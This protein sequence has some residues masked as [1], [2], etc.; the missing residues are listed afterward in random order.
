MEP[1]DEV[2][3]LGPVALQPD[4]G[5]PVDAV[6][7][8]SQSISPHIWTP[9]DISKP[10]RLRS[11]TS[12]FSKFN[13]FT[14]IEDKVYGTYL[15]KELKKHIRKADE[16]CNSVHKEII[17]TEKEIVAL[18]NK[19]DPADERKL[20]ELLGN[21][22]TLK[23]KLPELENI[24]QA[25]Q[26]LEDFQK[27]VRYSRLNKEMRTRHKYPLKSLVNH[28]QSLKK[29]AISSVDL[30]KALSQT[31]KIKAVSIDSNHLENVAR[32]DA[33]NRMMTT[34]WATVSKLQENST[35]KQTSQFGE[36]TKDGGREVTENLERVNTID[37]LAARYQVETAALETEIATAPEE[38]KKALQERLGALEKLENR[39]KG[40]LE[41]WRMTKWIDSSDWRQLAKTADTDLLEGIKI[42]PALRAD[43]INRLLIRCQGE[44]AKIEALPEHDK[45]IQETRRDALNELESQCVICWDR[46]QGPRSIDRDEWMQLLKLAA[47]A[48]LLHETVPDVRYGKYVAPVIVN[49][50]MHSVQAGG[51]SDEFH[52]SGAITDFRDGSTNL[53]DL[54]QADPHSAETAD[55][56]AVLD[57]QMVQLLDSQVRGWLKRQENLKALPNHFVLSQTSLLN[58]FKAKEVKEG[59]F[60]RSERNYM[61]D[62]EE[63]FK[64]FNN[65][66]LVLDPKATVAY[67]DAD[68][69]IHIPAEGLKA[70]KEITLTTSFFN[71]SVQVTTKNKGIQ[72][73]VNDLAFDSLRARVK[74]STFEGLP[75]QYVKTVTLE[76]LR[77]D[78]ITKIND[79]Q[80]RL[81]EEGGSYE[82]AAQLIHLQEEVALSDGAGSAKGINCF[83][84]KDRTGEVAKYLVR[85][86][87]AKALNPLGGMGK[88]EKQK[89]IADFE[90]HLA[91]PE[92]L[93]L[94]N[95]YENTGVRVMRNA[96]ITLLG[97]DSL[98][99]RVKRGWTAYGVQE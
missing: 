51:Y 9:I 25:A 11:G 90:K 75:K 1:I 10:P 36:V 5:Q 27:V 34:I 65:K 13:F 63:I 62:M 49:A 80:T 43:F 26:H 30:V 17:Q 66:T 73:E 77:E 29:R 91:S 97:E 56:R 61:L 82:L 54:E 40:C 52:Q 14:W 41:N 22:E 88:E 16:Y 53:R 20:T 47:G 55:R 19:H 59:G 76:K 64:E 35:G 96:A 94:Q 44:I 48:D 3:A 2:R 69:K 45:K 31:L 92:S 83:S 37:L 50:R 33:I 57:N 18:Q 32:K 89:K 98:W 71:V 81:N 68:D 46:C 58:P 85:D 38:K 87:Y 95:C 28:I 39:R 84:G 21:L 7:K 23:A 60:V 8:S 4:A 93:A 15:E 86:C 42:E 67:I 79:L 72:Q 12:W 24:A 70:S 6:R 74:A 99:K 78:L